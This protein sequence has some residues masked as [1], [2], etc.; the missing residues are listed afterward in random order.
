M[1]KH[2]AM[3]M[4]PTKGMSVCACRER[5]KKKG[6]LPSTSAMRKPMRR[7]QMRSPML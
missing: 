7:L 4:L 3:L 5:K 2:R 1:K 6:L